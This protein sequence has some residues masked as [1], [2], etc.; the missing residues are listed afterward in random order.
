MRGFINNV[1]GLAIV[2]LL[3]FLST[4]M[5]IA[6]YTV[7]S[8][9]M[10]PG[11]ESGQVL[12]INKFAYTFDRPER[13]DVIYFNTPD[14]NKDQLKRIIGLPG[15]VVEI[16]NQCLYINGILIQEPYIK[17]SAEY[18]MAQFQVP[19]GNYFVLSDNRNFTND[20]SSGWTIQDDD[21][22]GKAWIL[23]WPPDKWG[24]VDE[25]SIGSQLA[26]V[27]LN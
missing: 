27:D 2:A 14:G 1:L 6:S 10:S 21:I 8:D 18:E 9:S 4:R 17:Y 20:S 26:T 23:T 16:K 12:I 3:V 24:E 19:I 5:V 13:G 25:Y 15:D 7:I 22:M 11:L